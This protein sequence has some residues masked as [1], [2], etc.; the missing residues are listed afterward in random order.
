MEAWQ[1]T[2]EKLGVVEQAILALCSFYA[3]EDIPVDLFEGQQKI[4][5]GVIAL[6][7]CGCFAMKKK[8]MIQAKNERGNYGIY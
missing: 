7:A 2:W 8:I 1:T 4:V 5:G 6:L 3:S